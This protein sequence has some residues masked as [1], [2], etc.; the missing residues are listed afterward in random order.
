MDSVTNFES[1]LN[2]GV[3]V[4][5]CK[6]GSLGRRLPSDVFSFGKTV[7]DI[8]CTTIKVA[9]SDRENQGKGVR[10][11]LSVGTL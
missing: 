10:K 5:T 6:T 4:V 7:G 3:V 9:T 8:L 11:D 1:S 2:P